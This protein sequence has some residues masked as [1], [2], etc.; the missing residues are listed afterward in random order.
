MGVVET[1][2]AWVTK[3][4]G[5]EGV[6]HYQGRYRDPGEDGAGWLAFCREL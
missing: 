3:R 6:L 1:A 4:R 2:M 5:S